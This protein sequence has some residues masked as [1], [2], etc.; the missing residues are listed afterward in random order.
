MEVIEQYQNTWLKI[1]DSEY[2][3][4]VEKSSELSDGLPE[5][6]M[7]LANDALRSTEFAENIKERILSLSDES[8]RPELNVKVKSLLDGF[9]KVSKKA[10]QIL[11][12]IV[13]SDVKPAF[14]V[15]M[16]NPQWYEQEVMRF[17]VG[18]FL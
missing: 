15:L 8:F 4:F 1:L 14:H 5:Y 11:I 16:S 10:Y 2:S 9:M 7:A 3:K 17:I 18:M 12:E 6:A 13:M